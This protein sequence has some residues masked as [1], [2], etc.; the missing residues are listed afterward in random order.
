MKNTKCWLYMLSESDC[1]E[2][3]KIGITGG[4][5][6][7]RLAELQTGNPRKLKLESAW[8]CPDRASAASL[9]RSILEQ[10]APHISRGEWIRGDV[11]QIFCFV[12]DQAMEVMP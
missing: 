4:H 10:M 12:H 7:A 5:P 6:R 3:V 1:G 2:F 11:F 8:E 9:E